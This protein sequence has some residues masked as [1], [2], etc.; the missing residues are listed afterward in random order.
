MFASL[1]DGANKLVTE[2]KGILVKEALKYL[3]LTIATLVVGFLLAGIS[4]LFKLPT[5]LTIDN[6]WS[7]FWLLTKSLWEHPV[8][9]T[10]G[11]YVRDPIHSIVA[12]VVAAILVIA[13]VL[14]RRARRR[15]K[16]LA[17]SLNEAS[18]AQA[19]VS[20][21]GMTMTS[22]GSISA[23]TR[24]RI[25]PSESAVTG[26]FSSAAVPEG[27]VSDGGGMVKNER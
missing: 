2:S 4:Q 14:F 25:P 19:L 3:V 21:L 13:L 6:F 5:P 23:S 15:I 16:G 12:L 20:Q 9:F 26:A 8:D 11:L 7:Q 18:V 1:R 27:R 17:A 24:R 22:S 10:V